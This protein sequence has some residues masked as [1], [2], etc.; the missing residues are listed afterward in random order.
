[1]P[2]GAAQQQLG[3][4]GST[5]HRARAGATGRGHPGRRR[6]GGA[7]DHGSPAA[8]VLR[9]RGRGHEGS[10]RGAPGKVGSGAAHRGGRTS[11]GWWGAAAVAAFRWRR[12]ALE[13]EEDS[14]VDLQ[15][16]ERE[17]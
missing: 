2:E 9:G 11:M 6:R 16:G 15:A 3:P 14:G 1:M 8:R 7:G 17:G 13:G 5:A 10:G 4:T 12:A